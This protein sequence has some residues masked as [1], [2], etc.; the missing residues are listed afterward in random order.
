MRI[1]HGGVANENLFLVKGPLCEPL[2]ASFPENFGGTAGPWGTRVHFGH[3]RFYQLDGPQGFGDPRGTVDDD[4]GEEAQYLRRTV[5]LLAHAQQ[6]RVLV[7]ERGVAFPRQ[8]RGMG[9][10][11]LEKS[12]IGIDASDPEFLQRAVHHP[13]RFLQVQ[14][15]GADLHQERVVVR[16][17]VSAGKSIARVEPHTVPPWRA[18]CLQNPEIG[19]EIVLGVFSRDAALYGMSPHGYGILP[20]YA[21][22]RVG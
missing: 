9:H 16:R 6:F 11:V 10:H 22:F 3:P 21:D 5:L 1:P 15:P 18:V 14:P 8:E 13:R 12:D 19:S 7:D 4:V 20:R 2:G 17:N